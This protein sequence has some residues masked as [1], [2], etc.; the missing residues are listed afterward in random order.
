M[1][2]QFSYFKPPGKHELNLLKLFL[3]INLKILDK[4]ASTDEM[5]LCAYLLEVILIMLQ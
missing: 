4:Y 5:F 2:K 3:L 1:K